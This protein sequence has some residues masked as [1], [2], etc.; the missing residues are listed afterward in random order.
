MRVTN[1]GNVLVGT[2]T[3]VAS[4][5]ILQVSNGITFPATQSAVA[6]ANTLDDYEEG[7]WTPS[8]AGDSVAGTQTYTWR[9]ASYT[10]IGN[11]VFGSCSIIINVKD[12]TTAGSLLITG[13]P[14]TPNSN[15]GIPQGAVSIA[16]GLTLSS[17]S[18]Y[19]SGYVANGTTSIVLA[20]CGSGTFN[21]VP[22]T[23][24]ANGTQI[25]IAFNYYV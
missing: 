22:S 18:T 5:G 23:N 2:T 4:A 20:Q 24:F 17:G 1:D 25:Q 6:N 21:A 8:L 19:V 13:L 11:R 3:A 14:F 10:K 9:N 7:T 16:S 12:A 15:S